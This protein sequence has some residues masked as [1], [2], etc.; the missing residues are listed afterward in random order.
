MDSSLF[1]LI[2]RGMANPFF[3][4]IM[5]ALS[6]Q[7][8]L[9]VIPFLIYIILHRSAAARDPGGG[10]R[11]A[12]ALRAMAIALCSL[13]IV[14]MIEAFLKPAIGRVRPC[15]ALEGVR[16][17]TKCHEGFSMPSGHALS[18]FAFATPLFRLT[19]S[20]VPAGA[21]ACPLVLASLIAF[22]R[23]YV[24]VHYPS[25]VLA[26]ALIGSAVAEALCQAYHLVTARLR[27]GAAPGSR[28]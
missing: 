28:R 8:Y 17:L 27:R 24:G 18:S 12:T 9:L 15:H 1:F 22:S 3:D 10:R 23:V 19:R 2:N 11:T 26:G 13:F 5:P 20:A 25:D 7:G 6:N 4:V 14:D 16:V 21:R